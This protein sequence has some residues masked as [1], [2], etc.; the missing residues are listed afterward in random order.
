M[1]APV[2]RSLEYWAQVRGKDAA[3]LEDGRSLSWADWNDYANG[4]AQSLIGRGIAAGDVV[5]LRMRSRIEWAV[6]AWAIG[7]IDACLLSLDADLGAEEA[8]RILIDAG[9]SALICDGDDLSD[10]SSAV[11]NLPMKLRSTVDAAAPGF[12]NFWDLFPAVAPPRF[13]RAHPEEI[14]YTSTGGGPLRAVRIPRP[15]IAL[16]SQSRPPAPDNGASLITLTLSHSWAI[17]QLWS[18]VS[19]GRRI[20][21]TPRYEPVSA[22]RA[23]ER[24]GVT[25]WMDRAGTFERL[26][27]VP[28]RIIRRFNLASLKSISV[29]AGGAP[30]DL[31]TWLIATFGP[32]LTESYGMPETG[33]ITMLPPAMQP[34]RPGTCG[35]PGRGVM[36]E[37]RDPTGQRLP[38]N[39]IG[40][41]WART[42]GTIERRLIGPAELRDKNDFVRTGAS[43]RV[44]EDGY[45]YL[46]PAGES[47]RSPADASRLAGRTLR[48]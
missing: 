4:F 21:L 25:E 15:R 12:F 43:G 48:G 16:A 1:K 35:R 34:A 9:A 44:D 18:A 42:P 24:H 20:V 31:K 8:R 33:L 5:A 6:A 23:I 37:I 46:S 3:L 29:G 14:A 17:L 30:A 7:K 28:T 2:A 10:I 39:A 41:V 22:L 11:S 45:L 38:P 36:V 47:G 13:A 27:K 26:A 19:A 40:E 32:I